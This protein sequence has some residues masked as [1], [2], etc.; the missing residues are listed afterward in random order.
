[1]GRGSSHSCGEC[2]GPMCPHRARL[3]AQRRRPPRPVWF[4]GADAARNGKAGIVS[5]ALHAQASPHVLSAGW[6]P[7]MSAAME[8]HAPVIKVLLAAKANPHVCDA[9]NVSTATLAAPMDTQPVS[10]CCWRRSLTPTFLPQ[11][12][13][14]RH[15]PLRRAR[16]R[17]F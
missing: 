13:P 6:S 11:L 4:H 15:T 7:L 1:M 3:G 5:L 14:Q 10:C 9:F 2:R 17:C 8:G 12:A 16:R